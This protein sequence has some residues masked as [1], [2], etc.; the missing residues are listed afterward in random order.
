ML[1]YMLTGLVRKNW[2]GGF[3]DLEWCLQE[4]QYQ[5]H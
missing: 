5:V 2:R 3:R 1:F 4:Q